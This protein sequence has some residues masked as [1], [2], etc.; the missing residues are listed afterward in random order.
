[1]GEASTLIGS[2][3][4]ETGPPP[5]VT[6]LVGT[7]TGT[8][9]NDGTVNLQWTASTATDLDYYDVY[10]CDASGN[11]PE[12]IA[13]GTS[14][15]TTTGTTDSGWTFG[16]TYVYKVVAFDWVGKPNTPAMMAA[17]TA[18]VTVTID[19]SPTVAP[20]PP[21]DLRADLSGTSVTLTWAASP[22]G[23]VAGYH[24]WM[25]NGA[26]SS[27]IATVVAG[28]PSLTTSYEQGAG[29]DRYYTVK[30]YRAAS[31]DSTAT[32]VAAGYPTGTV[33]S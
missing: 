23:G 14:G 8:A 21:T 30:A 16:A 31:A 27:I 22:S 7:G 1:M 15:W 18:S 10:R 28:G 20:A 32:S 13:G 33:G 29:A 2:M 12:L 26:T 24:V 5:A 9:G 25:Y 17:S 11:N 19:Q 3:K 4:V 6:N